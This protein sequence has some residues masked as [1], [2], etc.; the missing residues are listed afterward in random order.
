MADRT[1]GASGCPH[2]LAPRSCEICRV[3]A[4][5]PAAVPAR[6]ARPQP[7]DRRR[8]GSAVGTGRIALGAVVAIVAVVVLVQVLA[9]VSMIVRLAQLVGVA[10]LAG[11]VG[12][13]LGVV[14]GRRDRS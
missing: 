4:E 12:W 3:L 13:R 2:G 10:A 8:G 14:A 9:V 11:Y 5:A 1:E 7:A 6:R